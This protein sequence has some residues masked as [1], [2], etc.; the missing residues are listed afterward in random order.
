MIKLKNN[1]VVFRAIPLVHYSMETGEDT[2]FTMKV[3]EPSEHQGVYKESIDNIELLER[4]ET[5]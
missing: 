3:I 2:M 5:L 1:P 4:I